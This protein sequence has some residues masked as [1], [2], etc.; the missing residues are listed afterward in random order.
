VIVIKKIGEIFEFEGNTFICKGV[1]VADVCNGCYF[2]NEKRDCNC[3]EIIAKV[4][5]C[6]GIARE[7][8]KEVVYSL[9]EEG[10]LFKKYV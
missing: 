2:L 5:F 7:D 9:L 3:R 8:H 1:S 4:G 6:S 10:R